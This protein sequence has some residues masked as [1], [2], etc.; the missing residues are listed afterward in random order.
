MEAGVTNI[1]WIS[2]GVSLGALI[3][4]VIAAANSYKSR[5]AAEAT[6]EAS[7]RAT[8]VQ[9]DEYRKKYGTPTFE[10]LAEDAFRCKSDEVKEMSAIERQLRR[11]ADAVEETRPSPQPEEPGSTP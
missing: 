7:R 6:A 9:E 3:V 8:K 4:A 1:E 2:L 5:K 10:S 11:I